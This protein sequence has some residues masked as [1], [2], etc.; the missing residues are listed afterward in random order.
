MRE[1][2]RIFYHEACSH[3]ESRTKKTPA[4]E[5]GAVCESVELESAYL[6]TGGRGGGGGMRVRELL[7]AREEIISVMR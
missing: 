6:A 7:A 1:I 4:L 2:G 3:A 5:A